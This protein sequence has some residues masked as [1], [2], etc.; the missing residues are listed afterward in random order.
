MENLG[1][2]SSTHYELYEYCY[3]SLVDFYSERENFISVC[4]QL[5]KI[6]PTDPSYRIEFLYNCSQYFEEIGN[7]EKAR[8]NYITIKEIYDQN[9][10][11]INS[12]IHAYYVLILF[13][14]QDKLDNILPYLEK[15]PTASWGLKNNQ[16]I[17]YAIGK[18]LLFYKQHEK[19]RQFF[20]LALRREENYELDSIIF[21]HIQ[22]IDNS[23]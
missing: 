22:E 17:L 16:N 13:T 11:S 3:V 2:A 23:L 19:A 9:I 6:I 18:G 15:I 5:E 10:H 4:N 20:M 1:S 7:K 8:E 14:L 21:K 12:D